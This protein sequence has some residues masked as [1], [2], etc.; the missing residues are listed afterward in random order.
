V[1]R[2]RQKGVKRGAGAW[3]RMPGTASLQPAPVHATDHA[4]PPKTL[5]PGI[6]AVIPY[7]VLNAVHTHP[8]G[9]PGL[10]PDDGLTDPDK[11]FNVRV[12][13]PW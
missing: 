4:P 1:G 2:G 13:V 11:K 10:P 9:S 7:A 6:T 5:R 12:L 3:V 8:S